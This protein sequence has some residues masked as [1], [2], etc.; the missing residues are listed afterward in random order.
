MAV[1]GTGS[2]PAAGNNDGQGLPAVLAAL[3]PAFLKSRLIDPLGVTG[4]AQLIFPDQANG[5]LLKKEDGTVIGSSLI[6]QNFTADKYFHGR[7]SWSRR[8][9]LRTRVVG[10]LV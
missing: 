10:L 8:P 4:I 1:A 7:P 5:S 6:G 3:V 2:T 9:A